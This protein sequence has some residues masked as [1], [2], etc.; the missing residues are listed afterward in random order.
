VGEINRVVLIVLD[1]VGVGE[2][3]DADKFGDQGSNTLGHVA[4]AAGGL[5]LPNLRWMGIGNI[6]DIE[7]VPPIDKPWGAYGKMNELNHEKAT[8]SGHWEMAGLI[9]RKRF[10]T[11]PKGFPEEIVKTF[12]KAIGREILGNKKASGT[13]IIEEYG[14]EHIESG[15]PIVY[16][17]ADSVFQIAA[18]EE[19]IPVEKLYEFCKIARKMLTGKYSVERVIARPFVGEPG[20]LVRTDRRK[21]FSVPPPEKTL[22]D[23]MKEKGYQVVGIGKIPDIFAH[24]GLTKEIHTK[25]NMDG[26]NKLILTMKEKNK[27]LIFINLVDFDSLY[28][29]R[30]NPEGYANALE[31]FDARLPQI[32]A[33]LREDNLLILTADHGCDPTF[34]GTDHTR[35][36][37]PLLVYGQRTKGGINLGTRE[38]FADIAQTIAE[39]FGLQPFK[40]G[41]SF[42]K[43]ILG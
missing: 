37:V 8:T 40:I 31:A 28:G 7:G 38:T 36:Y 6:I 16:T 1:S 24:Q 32:V 27:G 15:K 11:Y 3:P 43:E 26:T 25:G 13:V 14:S 23:K 5:S 33:N 39:L 9:L 10:P 34:P 41:K 35:E 17:S 22:L 18:H 29:H 30:N 2:L 21:D 12:S 19:V 42:K 20:Y 4:Q